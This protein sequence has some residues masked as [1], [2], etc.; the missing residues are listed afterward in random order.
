MNRTNLTLL[1]RKQLKRTLDYAT[2]YLNDNIATMSKPTIKRMK[3]YISDTQM[4]YDR[5][6]KILQDTGGVMSGGSEVDE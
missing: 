2:G 5:A 4:D 1:L 6:C 3:K